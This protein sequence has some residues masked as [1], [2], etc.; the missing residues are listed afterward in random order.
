MTPCMLLRL[1]L[2]RLVSER[3]EPVARKV[4]ADALSKRRTRAPETRVVPPPILSTFPVRDPN[5][6]FTGPG[7]VV[8]HRTSI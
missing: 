6:H 1:V 5:H 2:D 3:H 4:V 8:T 7:V